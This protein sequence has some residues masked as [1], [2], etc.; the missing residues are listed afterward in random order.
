MGLFDLPC[1]CSFTSIEKRGLVAFIAL[2]GSVLPGSTAPA[3]ADQPSATLIIGGTG[4]ALGAMHLLA[5]EFTKVHSNIHVTVLPSLGS[6]GGIKA[7]ADG[8]I[9]L[10][11]SARPLKQAEKDKGLRAIE[12]ARTPMVFATSHDN[13]AESISLEQMVSLYAGEHQTWPDGTPVRL[14]MRPESEV[15]T[16][17]IRA[18]SAEMDAAVKSALQRKELH[19]AINDQDNA[20]A[21]E[22]IPGSLG[23]V[24]LAQIMTEERRIKPLV[25]DGLEGT[26]ETLGA[27]KYPYAKTHYIVSESQ[28][29]PEAQAFLEFIASPEGQ[30]I[31]RASGHVVADIASNSKM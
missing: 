22:T 17:L 29:A 31:L 11:L 18:I 8:K 1:F 10:A 20:S 5:R 26:V 25:F 2:I 7:V 9:S 23:L 27:G 13:P 3:V 30:D 15:D 14:I 16:G 19:L 21:L 12:Y 24:S 28:P 4:S 6:G